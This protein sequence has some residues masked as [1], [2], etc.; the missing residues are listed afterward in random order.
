MTCSTPLEEAAQTQATP[1]LSTPVGG[2]EGEVPRL[3]DTITT[4]V[5]P[6]DVPSEAHVEENVK[7]KNG[8][9]GR[10]GEVVFGNGLESNIAPL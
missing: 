8:G 2:H 9:N 1:S 6:L 5:Y 3:G 10:E 7:D 4:R